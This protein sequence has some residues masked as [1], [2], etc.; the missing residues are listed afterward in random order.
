MTKA[1]SKASLLDLGNNNILAIAVA[2]VIVVIILIFF[3]DRQQQR[4]IELRRIETKI[5]LY[6]EW[7]IRPQQQ[8]QQPNTQQSLQQNNTNAQGNGGRIF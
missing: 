7:G 2:A 3:W 8:L 5:E 1:D 6:E 4:A